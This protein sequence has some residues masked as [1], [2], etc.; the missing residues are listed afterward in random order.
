MVVHDAVGER[1]AE[2]GALAGF[3]GREERLEDLPQVPGLDAV[4][5]VSHLDADRVRLPL[6][7]ATRKPGDRMRALGLK[8]PKRLQDI[9]VDAHV[10]R[11]VRDSL[12]VV[13]DSEEIVWI[14]GVTVAESKRV[15]SATQ[16]QLHLEIVHP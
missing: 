3:L 4:T 9:L 13:S 12:P 11:Q 15:T 5:V 14:P 16:R 10:P 1:Q 8:E 2:S 7:V 6:T